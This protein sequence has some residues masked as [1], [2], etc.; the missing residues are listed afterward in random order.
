[1]PVSPAGEFSFALGDGSYDFTIK[2]E[3]FLF[4]LV[5]IV[6]ISSDA[7]EEDRMKIRPPWC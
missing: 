2:A 3:G 4:K 5:G 6:V 7:S 1:V